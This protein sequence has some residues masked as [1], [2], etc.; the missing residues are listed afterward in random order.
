MFKLTENAT[1]EVYGCNEQ[2]YKSCF[3]FA[4]KNNI[5][6]LIFEFDGSTAQLHFFE[7]MINLYRSIGV[8]LKCSYDV[9]NKA[10][11]S[12]DCELVFIVETNQKNSNKYF[13][14]VY[15]EIFVKDEEAIMDRYMDVE[16]VIWNLEFCKTNWEIFN[17]KIE[18]LIDGYKRNE[19]MLSNVLLTNSLIREHPC[20]VYLCTG[21][22]CHSGHGNVPRYITIEANGQ[23]YPYTL[24]KDEY[25]L[26]NISDVS[27][28]FEKQ[29][30]KSEAKKNFVEINRKLYVN[31]FDKC[32][33]TFIPWFDLLNG[34]LYDCKCNFNS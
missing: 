1:I 22:R 9:W 30:Q 25:M 27:D 17:S 6:R 28:D 4:F 34:E 24:K 5:Q 7:T 26:G 2:V 12:T 11:I 8:F 20:N 13:P 29:Y 15:W 14:N 16:N 32:N 10:D 3:E 31:I 18:Y 19:L 23:M 33:Y 21:E